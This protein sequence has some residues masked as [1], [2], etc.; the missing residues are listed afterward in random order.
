MDFL[1]KKKKKKKR[2]KEQVSQIEFQMEYLVPYQRFWNGQHY[3]D[4]P[5]IYSVP[6]KRTGC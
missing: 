3:A 4:V 2:K 6:L 1:K 5:F